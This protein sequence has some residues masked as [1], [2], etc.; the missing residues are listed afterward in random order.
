M[1]QQDLSVGVNKLDYTTIV[2][3]PQQQQRREWTERQCIPSCDVELT[4][5][6]R[7]GNS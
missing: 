7:R 6:E 3:W 2:W 5:K 4:A 1:E